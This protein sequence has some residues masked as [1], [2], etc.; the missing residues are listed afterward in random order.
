VN[1]PAVLFALSFLLLAGCVAKPVDQGNYECPDGTKTTNLALCDYLND[2]YNATK[3]AFDKFGNLPVFDN[4]A[5]NDD[6][7]PALPDESAPEE[8]TG[9]N[10]NPVYWTSSDGSG[11]SSGTNYPGTPSTPTATPTATPTP[12][13]PPAPP[14][15]ILAPPI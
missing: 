3:P 15:D 9:T 14:S 5:E 10:A 11:S 7:P 13:T 1:K 8:L 6:A 12:L 4:N 2:K